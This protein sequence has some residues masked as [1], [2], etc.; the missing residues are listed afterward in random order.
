MDVL[1]VSCPYKGILL[2]DKG[3]KHLVSMLSERSQSQ[4]GT[5]CMV[6]FTGVLKTGNVIEKESQESLGAARVLQWA[7]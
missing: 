7:R 2:G 6:P 1:N 4:K 5:Y 3:K